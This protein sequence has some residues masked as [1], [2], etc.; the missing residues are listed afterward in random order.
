MRC[1]VALC[2]DVFS[3]L[4][5]RWWFAVLPWPVCKH[6]EW[7]SQLQLSAHIRLIPAMSFSAATEIF[8]IF[9]YFLSTESWKGGSE[10]VGAYAVYLVQMMIVLIIVNRCFSVVAPKTYST[11]LL[12][13]SRCGHYERHNCALLWFLLKFT[14]LSSSSPAVAVAHYPGCAMI[15]WQK[16]ILAPGT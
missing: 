14:S 7:I 4:L 9:L 10:L 1:F 11:V 2:I 13:K 15:V 12:R 5:W 16:K 3:P 8:L 6:E